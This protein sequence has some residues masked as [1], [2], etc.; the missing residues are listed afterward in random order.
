MKN[1]EYIAQIYEQHSMAVYHYLL[2]LFRSE[3]H[4]EETLQ[5]VFFRFFTRS[6]QSEIENIR[7]YLFRIAHN[8]F[9]DF[10][11]KKSKDSKLLEKIDPAEFSDDFTVDIHFQE[12]R[13]QIQ[14]CLRATKPILE[15]AFILRVDQNLTY[16]E[17][18]YVLKISERTVLRYFEDIKTI[19][20]QNFKQELNL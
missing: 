2:K 1:D 14:D 9:V 8:L 19:L 11:A 20:I 10:V 5:E 15:E 16:A 7:S 18:S 3:D 6:K 17:I 12:L 13:K 4:A